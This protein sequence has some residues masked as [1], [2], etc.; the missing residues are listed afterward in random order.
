MKTR[1]RALSV[2]FNSPVSQVQY[3]Q[4]PFS[5]VSHAPTGA[6]RSSKRK[7][8]DVV[9]VQVGVDHLFVADHACGAA[10]QIPL[11]RLAE[12]VVDPIELHSPHGPEVRDLVDTPRTLAVDHH[13][14]ESPKSRHPRVQPESLNNYLGVL[15][16]PLS[17]A[18]DDNLH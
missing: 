6:W 11:G 18:S 17:T 3:C 1:A 4:S 2:S 7:P 15:V 13:Q 10:V 12:N 16:R 14:A 8:K 5:S 9:G